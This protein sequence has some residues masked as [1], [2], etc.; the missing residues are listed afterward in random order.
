MYNTEIQLR[1]PSCYIS[2]EGENV[3]LYWFSTR[4]GIFRSA[5]NNFQTRGGVAGEIANFWWTVFHPLVVLRLYN[6][7]SWRI[8][9]L[10]A[11]LA[12]PSP[13]RAPAP[14][15]APAPAPVQ[16]RPQPR[17]QPHPPQAPSP[18][19]PDPPGVCF[20]VA[21]VSRRGLRSSGR[22][23]ARVVP[24][25]IFPRNHLTIQM[26]LMVIFAREHDRSRVPPG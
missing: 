6:R 16:P 2:Y 20:V 22:S 8:D 14:A 21:T 4:G 24:L 5:S 17:P 7:E 19:N 10:V 12:N 23:R 25:N 9:E 11:E 15:S 13:A 26:S 1:D 18:M 3:W